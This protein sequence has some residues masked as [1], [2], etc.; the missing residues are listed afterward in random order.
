MNKVKLKLNHSDA[1]V[2]ANH[3]SD[4]IGNQPANSRMAQLVEALLLEC[5]LKIQAKSFFYYQGHK[6][7][8]FTMPQSIALLEVLLRFTGKASTNDY[9][10]ILFTQITGTLDQKL[11]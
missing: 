5:Y 7:I 6:A 8:S 11:S 3:L 1:T 10:Y 2:L 4:A 9:R